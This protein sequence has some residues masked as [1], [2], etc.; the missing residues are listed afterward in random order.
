MEEAG[1]LERSTA[2]LSLER[3]FSSATFSS[4]FPELVAKSAFA[5]EELR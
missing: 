3:G 2:T 5:D 4:S 1:A